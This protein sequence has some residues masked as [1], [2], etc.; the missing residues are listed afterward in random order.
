MIF[1]HE[2]FYILLYYLLTNLWKFL[3]MKRHVEE[4]RTSNRRNCHYEIL[5]STV[6]K[7]N[8]WRIIGNGRV[9]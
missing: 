8:N 3:S 7:L 1:D 6:N 9:E 2:I 5:P 4:N